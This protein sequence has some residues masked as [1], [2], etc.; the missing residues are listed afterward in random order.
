MMLLLS[1]DSALPLVSISDELQLSLAALDLD[2][3]PGPQ[4]L[5]L[6]TCARG[7]AEDTE[8]MSLA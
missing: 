3:G 7:G 5:H 1:G 8:S 4:T 6:L 2:K